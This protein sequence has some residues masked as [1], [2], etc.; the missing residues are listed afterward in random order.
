MQS[1]RSDYSLPV[2]RRIAE[3]SVPH[4]LIW[5]AGCGAAS[6]RTLV[7]PVRI[8]NADTHAK[9]EGAGPM[10]G[11]RAPFPTLRWRPQGRPRTAQG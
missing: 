7:A 8:A 3:D 1:E 11:L 2:S 5:I 10:T 9:V 6:P 4:L